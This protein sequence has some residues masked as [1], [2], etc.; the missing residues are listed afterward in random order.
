M[1]KST[2]KVEI[3]LTLNEKDA[4]AIVYAVQVM[5][6]IPGKS[7]TPTYTYDELIESALIIRHELEDCL[8][9]P[10]NKEI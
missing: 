5:Q 3:T 1:M 8:Q 10:L 2:K 4:C 7:D 6:S 9:N